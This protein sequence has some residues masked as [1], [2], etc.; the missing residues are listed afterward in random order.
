MIIQKY[1]N[2]LTF[3]KCQSHLLWAL[4]YVAHRIVPGN[5]VM[6]CPQVKNC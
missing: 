1:L 2:I 6:F 4:G 3:Q 5:K